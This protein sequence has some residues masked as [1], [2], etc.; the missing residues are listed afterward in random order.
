MPFLIL[1]KIL[2]YQT[3]LFFLGGTPYPTIHN[4]DLMAMLKSG[5]RMER[6]ENCAQQLCVLF[7]TLFFSLIDQVMCNSEIF[8]V[9]VM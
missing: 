9:N 7:S 4:K 5:Y 6:P 8:K 2:Y 1:F 3:L